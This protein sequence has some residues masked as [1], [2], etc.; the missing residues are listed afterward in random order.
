MCGIAGVWSVRGPTDPAALRRMAASLRHRG[1]D[2]TGIWTDPSAGIGLAHARLAVLDLSPTGCQP[3]TSPCGRYV[4]TFNGEIYNFLDL[5][6]EL[7]AAGVTFRGRS[8]TEVMLATFSRHGVER[9]LQSFN[10]MFAFG[11]WDREARRLHL[12]RDRFGEKPLYYG[13][14]KDGFFFG[15]E[16]KALKRLHGLPVEVDRDAL[17]LFIRFG[18]VPTPHSIYQ[19]IHK[20]P[21]GSLL[22]LERPDGASPSPRPYWSLAQ[23]CEEGARHPVRCS[24]AE[25]ATELEGI[26]KDAVKLRMAADVPLGALLSGGVD[27]SLIVS[28]MQAVSTRP[29]KTFTIGL[30]EAYMDESGHARQV[31]SHLGTDHT[32]LRV[33]PQE[34]L[35]VIPSLPELYDE[36]F[37]D[38]SQ[39]PT[40]LISRLARRAVTVSLSG[41]GGDEVFGGYTR[42]STAPALWRGFGWIP[43]S[44]RGAVSRLMLRPSVA[45][46]ERWAWFMAPLLRPYAR[47]ASWGDAFRKIAETIRLESPD[48]IHLR[49]AGVWDRAEE[50]L[51]TDRRAPLPPG[52]SPPLGAPRNHAE[53]MMYV[54]AMTYLPDDILAKVDRAS[55]SVG[56]EVR[57]PFLDPRVADYAWRLPWDWKARPKRGKWIL[58]KILERYVPPRLT[59]RPKMGF[60]MPVADW[61]R[62]PLR[63]WAHS[64][65]DEKRLKEQGF[66]R[67]EPILAKWRE[68]LS[69]RRDWPFPLWNVLMFQAWLERWHAPAPTRPT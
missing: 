69:G 1:P 12:A 45:Q 68:H 44:L 36:P 56:L 67:P 62:G 39:I 31:A 10:G 65:L 32:E 28:L 37:A 20:L 61:L 52:F 46:W 51:S 40:L 35:S 21:P 25:A 42:Y 34:A 58:R 23:V 47:Q 18:Y 60:T 17:A 29:V 14:G 38:S 7:E 22:T 50:V 15:S 19:G 64:L 16:L 66:L 24:P 13:W 6:R 54:D 49:L 2:D 11:L 5:R 33:T 26:L 59:E 43:L 41:D 48:A 8:D 53:R 63:D 3:M 57:V 55:M 4:V 27:S 9:A 30:T